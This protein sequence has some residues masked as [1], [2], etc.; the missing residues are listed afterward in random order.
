MTIEWRQAISLDNEEVDSD[1]KYLI[2]LVNTVEESLE[3]PRKRETITVTLDLLRDYANTHFKRE[4]RL[5]EQVGYP[6][7]AEHKNHHQNLLK[8]LSELEKKILEKAD[9]ENFDNEP[10]PEHLMELLRHWL[11]GHIIGA[12]LRMKPWVGKNGT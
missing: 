7:L 8:K 6:G 12:D 9:P 4:E 3:Y 10:F 1:H 11:I 5:M 2:R